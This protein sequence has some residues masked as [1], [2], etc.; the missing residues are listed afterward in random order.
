MCYTICWYQKH[1]TVDEYNFA[2]YA[3]EVACD[4]YAGALKVS[5]PEIQA[6]I[7]KLVNAIDSAIEGSEV[8]RIRYAL[9]DSEVDNAP[10]RE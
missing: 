1:R 9:D 2:D 7:D 5:N 3:Q 4:L 8:D 6:E 10:E